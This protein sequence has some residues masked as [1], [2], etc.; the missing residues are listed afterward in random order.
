M[1]LP[2][3]EYKV[4]YSSQKLENW[5]SYHNHQ[6]AQAVGECLHHAFQLI[7]VFSRPLAWFLFLCGSSVWLRV[8]LSSHKCLFMFVKWRPF[9]SAQFQGLPEDIEL[10]VSWVFRNFPGGWSIF[11]QGKKLHNINTKLPSYKSLKLADNI[12]NCSDK[13]CIAFNGHNL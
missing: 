5:N 10:F 1:T 6:A 7:W 3:K 2:L 11:S 8:S 9:E 13:D 12:L 4:H